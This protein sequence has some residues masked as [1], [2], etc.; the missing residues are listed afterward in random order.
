[1][2]SEHA[3]N[4]DYKLVKAKLADAKELVEELKPK[5]DKEG[6]SHTFDAVQT[7]DLA[8]G[9]AR[10]FGSRYH[11]VAPPSRPW[12]VLAGKAESVPPGPA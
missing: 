12:L 9:L 8:T 6:R 3:I 7:H 4:E 10:L 1:M 11:R 5:A 2:S